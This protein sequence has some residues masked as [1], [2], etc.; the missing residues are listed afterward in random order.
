MSAEIITLP[1][2]RVEPPPDAQ[3]AMTVYLDH[4]FINKLRIAAEQADSTLERMAGALII[5]GL[6]ALEHKKVE[7]FYDAV[8]PDKFSNLNL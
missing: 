6:A 4:P 3:V 5:W 1:V 7:D 8:L 2:I